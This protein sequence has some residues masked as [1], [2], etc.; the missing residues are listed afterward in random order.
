MGTTL[1]EIMGAL[2]AVLIPVMLATIRL[3]PLTLMVPLFGGRALPSNV[4]M[5]LLVVLVVGLVPSIL[6]QPSIIR[7]NASLLLCALREASIGVVIAL[8]LS[9][10][11]LAVEYAGRWI[12]QSRGSSS[13]DALSLDGQ[14]RGGPMSELLR[15]TWGCVFLASG[16]FRALLLSIAH[17]FSVWPVD[18][19]A[20]HPALSQQWIELSA[21]WSSD[22][23]GVGV[24]LAASALLAL[25]ATEAVFAVA[26][27]ISPAIAQ[28]GLAL[29]TRLLVGLLVLALTLQQ[30]ANAAQSWAAQALHAVR[31]L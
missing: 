31:A 19:N 16:G 2:G 5:P 20:S 28:G 22:T 1:V 15:W 21:R 26:A 18:L 23:L 17:S 14:S 29:P 27:K 12:D 8:V 13:S 10:P 11:F 30:F 3:I 7:L 6:Q 4:R 24:A 25:V 9:A